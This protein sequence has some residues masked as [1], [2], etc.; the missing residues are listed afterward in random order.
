MARVS[1][2]FVRAVSLF[3]SA[4]WRRWSPIIVIVNSCSIP[5]MPF[6]GIVKA[7]TIFPLRIAFCRCRTVAAFIFCFLSFVV[8]LANL[9]TPSTLTL[10]RRVEGVFK[11]S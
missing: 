9:K 8:L 3:P 11:C 6:M 5:S 7:F 10:I 1:P 4:D 2:A